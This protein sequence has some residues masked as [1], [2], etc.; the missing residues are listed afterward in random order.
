M[1][2]GSPSGSIASAIR[3][4]RRDFRE[5]LVGAEQHVQLAAMQQDLLRG[6]PAAGGHVENAPA[7]LQLLAGDDAAEG[8]RQ[9]RHHAR[10][11]EPAAQQQ[12]GVGLAQAMRVIEFAIGLGIQ[13]A[14]VEPDTERVEIFGLGRREAADR[15]GGRANPRGRYGRGES[16]S[17][18]C[19]SIS[20]RGQAGRRKA[21]PK[22]RAST[23]LSIPVS[24]SAKPS[25]SSMR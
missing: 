21:P 20:P 9:I 5:Y 10:I 6:V 23:A 19:A 15:S 13:R 3:H 11:A 8:A 4:V 22:A 24:M 17:Q 2:S 25:P 1:P 7:D 18:G 14:G 12:F 16:A